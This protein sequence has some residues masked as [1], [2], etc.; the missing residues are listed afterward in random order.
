MARKRNMATDFSGRV[1]SLTAQAAEKFWRCLVLA[2][3]LG[4]LLT[5]S[6]HI[7]RAAV[8]DDSASL[9]WAGDG[10]PSRLDKGQAKLYRSIFAA[11]VDG[12]WR[13]AR[14]LI[15][16]LTDHSLMGHVQAQRYLHPTKYRSKFTELRNWMKKYADH[17]QARRIYKLAMRRKPRKAR[18]P[19]APK[20]LQFRGPSGYYE[21]PDITRLYLR[22]GY[23]RR[24][25]RRAR[26]Y[27]KIIRKSVVRRGRNGPAERLLNKKHVR[28]LYSAMGY[29]RLLGLIAHGYLMS[30]D[31]RAAYR[32]ASKAAGRSGKVLPEAHWVAGLAAFRV[33]RVADA[34]RHF[35]AVGSSDRIGLWL[36]SAGNFW[37]ARSYYRAGKPAQAGD[38]LRAAA[39]LPYTFYGVLAVR[40]LGIENQLDWALPL[41]D[42]GTLRKF[43]QYGSGKR[44]FLLLQ[45]GQKEL[46]EKEFR[47][48]AAVVKPWQIRTLVTLAT[49]AGMASLSMQ[50]GRKINDQD[51]G[52]VMAAIYPVPHWKPMRGFTLDR[53]LMFALMRQESAFRPGA[54]SR[55]GAQ[56][57]MQVMPRTA[58]FVARNA[59]LGRVGRARMREPN[60]NM[61]LGQS[62]LHHLLKELDGNLFH[63]VAAYNAG[64]G[65]VRKWHRRTEKYNNDPLMFIEGM[66][67]SE[68]RDFVERVFTNLWMYR[69]RLGQPVPSLDAI[70]AGEWPRYLSVE[71]QAS[72]S[73]GN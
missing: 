48:L 55:K 67:A 2:V 37:A 18:R 19:Q 36:R 62:Y 57:L 70:S 29:D 31:N 49:E 69:L 61:Q 3:V 24:N 17:P 65:N 5:S 20:T 72:T 71:R 45:V 11:Q 7:G 26:Y 64:P 25:K 50:L 68:T 56:G 42:E 54:R 9:D 23:G 51:G 34:A 14:R 39:K 63:V 38:S 10:F 28:K 40:L 46:A 52:V 12:K 33:G 30:G 47:R 22:T 53:A 66:R 1:A 27:A 16:K 73:Y 41:V 32:A 4:G 8:L 59:R 15:K 60:F 13:E 44:G 21:A 6:P 35:A 58:A 43:A